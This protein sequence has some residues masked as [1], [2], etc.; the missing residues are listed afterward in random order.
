MKKKILIISYFFPPSNSTASSRPFYWSKA[1]SDNGHEVVVLSKNWSGNNSLE[2]NNFSIIETKNSRFKQYDIEEYI[3]PIRQFKESKIINLTKLVRFI[4]FI[5][6][7]LGNLFPKLFEYKFFY[8]KAIELMEI[9][10]FD[11]VIISGGPH[12]TFFIGYHLKRKFSRIKWIAD[13][14]DEWNSLPKLQKKQELLKFIDVYFEKKWTS[15][16]NFFIY[17][18]NSY[19]NRLSKFINKPGVV[20]ENGYNPPLEINRN[21]DKNKFVFSFLGTL[22]PRYQNIEDISFIL[23]EVS[24]LTERKVEIYFIGSAIDTESED[25]I[26]SH[27]NWCNNITITERITREETAKYISKTDVFLMFPFYKMPGIVPTK[28]FDY[29]PYKLP[30]LFYPKDNGKIDNLLDETQLGFSGKTKEEIINSILNI[31]NFSEFGN[32]N[33]EKFSR[34]SNCLKLIRIIDELD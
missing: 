10:N 34:E 3:T 12:R 13:Y 15:N 29:L 24:L 33:I 2:K 6:I 9:N 26:K 31:H 30:I 14:R 7:I 20:I 19:L 23:K 25:K 18:N 32:S 11:T 21:I 4:T 5:E 1:L 8:K 17:V 27:F 16:L 28:L 22:Y